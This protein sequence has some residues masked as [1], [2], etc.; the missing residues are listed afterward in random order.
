MKV[1]LSYLR[2]ASL[3]VT[4]GLLLLE[5]R[6]CLRNQVGLVDRI[7]DDLL[8]FWVEAFGQV[9]IELRLLLL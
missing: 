7:G 9:L 5:L 2:R 1:R 6:S 4:I 3:C 8:L